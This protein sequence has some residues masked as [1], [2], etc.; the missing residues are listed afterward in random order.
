MSAFSTASSSTI[1]VFSTST[2]A[3]DVGLM[4]QFA[5]RSADSEP[6]LELTLSGFEPSASSFQSAIL[7]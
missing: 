3:T 2:A 5:E 6:V 4:P 7:P 1:A